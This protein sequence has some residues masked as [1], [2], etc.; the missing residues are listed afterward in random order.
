[1]KV[2]GRRRQSNK[3]RTS[4]GCERFKKCSH[5]IEMKTIVESPLM[6]SLPNL[7]AIRL[8][9]E[10]LS[11]VRSSIVSTTLASNLGHLLIL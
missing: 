10:K 9:Q 8:P 5:P 7:A 1:M 6:H 3:D 11:R 2:V 4:P